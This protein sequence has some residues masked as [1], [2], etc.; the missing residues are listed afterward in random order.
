MFIIGKLKLATSVFARLGFRFLVMIY[1]EPLKY[2][3]LIRCFLFLNRIL[4]KRKDSLRSR[5]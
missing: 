5:M 2:F 3:C 1:N 4:F